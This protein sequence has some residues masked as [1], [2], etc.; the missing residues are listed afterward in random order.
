MRV[1]VSGCITLQKME[2]KLAVCLDGL[3]QAF[4]WVV[5]L[6]PAPTPP[7][8][9]VLT[10]TATPKPHYSTAKQVANIRAGPGTTYEVIDTVDVSHMLLVTGRNEAG[11]WYQL[12]NGKWI[13]AFLVDAPPDNLPIVID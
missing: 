10:A 2:T 6:T 9:V 4:E 12:G 1:Q 11:D 7:H 13:A 5:E 3:A 8:E